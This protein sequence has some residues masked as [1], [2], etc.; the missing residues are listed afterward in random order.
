MRVECR[1]CRPAARWMLVQEGGKRG[2]KMG[3]R[4]VLEKAAGDERTFIAR[5]ASGRQ[6]Y[7]RRRAVKGVTRPLNPMA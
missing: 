7:R 1:R 5:Q 4:E 6:M 3:G 2:E